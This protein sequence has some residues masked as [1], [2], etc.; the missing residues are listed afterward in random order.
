MELGDALKQA[1]AAGVPAS[2]AANILTTS[3]K[4]RLRRY[5]TGVGQR[6]LES[7]AQAQAKPS[8]RALKERNKLKAVLTLIRA[9]RAAMGH[10]KVP[11]AKELLILDKRVAPV[12]IVRQFEQPAR[13]AA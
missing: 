12:L 7:H 11:V 5:F 10:R 8:A 1:I 9:R 2:L 4:L 6:F 13:L 3:N